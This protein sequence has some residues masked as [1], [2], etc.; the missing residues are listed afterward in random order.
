MPDEAEQGIN[1]WDGL[2]RFRFRFL[3]TNA[4]YLYISWRLRRRVAQ[5]REFRFASLTMR[6]V[7]ALCSGHVSKCYYP[8]CTALYSKAPGSI[9]AYCPPEE[10]HTASC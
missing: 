7:C 3:R 1:L 9:P 8:Y 5:S 4:V 2:E 10:F 6:L